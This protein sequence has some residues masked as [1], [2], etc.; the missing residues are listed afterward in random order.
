MAWTTNHW[1]MLPPSV[2]WENILESDEL[3]CESG[4]I[5]YRLGDHEQDI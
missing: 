2:S 1:E 3:E 5:T 4:F